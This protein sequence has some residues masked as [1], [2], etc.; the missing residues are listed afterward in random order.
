MEYDQQYPSVKN[1]T[2]EFLKNFSS[3]PS[4]LKIL[5]FGRFHIYRDIETDTT[6]GYS[7][8]LSYELLNNESELK[9]NNHIFQYNHLLTLISIEKILTN[10]S[11]TVIS[12]SWFDDYG[13]KLTN[14]D[15]L[16]LKNLF[17]FNLY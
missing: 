8:T 2:I 12:E 11:S 1:E 13:R 16:A 3:H 6:T 5:E 14:N 4:S 10:S 7:I 15:S 9:K 17:N